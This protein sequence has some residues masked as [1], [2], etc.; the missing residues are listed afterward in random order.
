M[1][2]QRIKCSVDG[3]AA[4]FE[5][6]YPNQGF[7][8]WGHISGLSATI[9]TPEGQQLVTTFY[10]CPEHLTAFGK[11]LQGKAQIKDL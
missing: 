10:I 1:I 8:N 5:E 6:S 4:E 3:C 2:T 7:P 9:D 11:V